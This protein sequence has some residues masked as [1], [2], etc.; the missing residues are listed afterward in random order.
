MPKGLVFVWADKAY[1][2]HI[3]DIMEKKGFL[4]VENFEII[5]M[6]IV[7]ARELCAN[8]YKTL[9]KDRIMNDHEELSALIPYL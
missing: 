2:A 7:K 8:T 9:N 3:L 5:N 4:Y 6:D 1:V